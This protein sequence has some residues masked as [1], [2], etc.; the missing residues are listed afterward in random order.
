[1]RKLLVLLLAIA[2]VL[3]AVPVEASDSMSIQLYANSANIW[4][5]HYGKNITW[6]FLEIWPANFLLT[7]VGPPAFSLSDNIS[8]TVAAGP[9][10]SVEGKDVFQSFTVDAVPVISNDSFLAVLINEAGITKDGRIKYFFRYTMTYKNVG[11]R[12]SGSGLFGDPNEHLQIGPTIK[13]QVSK[14]F[15]LEGWFAINPHNNEK[16]FEVT[17][18]IGL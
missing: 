17:F 10:F 1:M 12:W 15:S 5:F 2:F 13:Y 16:N 6:Y 9:D 8:L 4:Y 3:M 18:N 7:K 11:L 14:K